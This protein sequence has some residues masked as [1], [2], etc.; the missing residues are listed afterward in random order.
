MS[1]RDEIREAAA[2]YPDA[3]SGV[4]NGLHLA[5]EQYGWLPPE[6]LREVADAL[7]LTPAHVQAVASFYDMYH[8]A[9]VGEHLVEICTNVSCALA[10]AQQ[11][12]ESFER[13]LDL[14]AGETSDDGKVTLRTIECAGGC[15]SA[16]VVLVD[17]RYREPTRPDDVAGIV[18]ELRG[19]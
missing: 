3:R 8:L 1:L 17:H 6:A 16:P 12:V 4:M 19:G 15:G 14:R 9:P 7:D 5:Q 2:P 13:E 10:G 18:V 11:V